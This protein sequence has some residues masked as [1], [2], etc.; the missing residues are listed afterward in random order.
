VAAA[1]PAAQ[2]RTRRPARPH[3]RPERARLPGHTAIPTQT[4]PRTSTAARTA[5]LN[6]ILNGN[7]TAVAALTGNLTA[8]LNR[9]L[10]RNLTPDLTS[11]WARGRLR[12][13]PARQALPV[14]RRRPDAYDCS[15]LVWLAWEHAGL[16]WERMTAAAQWQWLHDRGG[17]VPAN[18]LRPGDLLFYAN[19]PDN[20]ASIHHVAMHVGN[21]RMVEAPQPGIPVRVVP[22]RWEGLYAA[23]PAP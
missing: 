11:D 14:G 3:R 19:N 5:I 10:D 8:D 17:D 13:G 6:T 12:A 18:Q 4:H 23:R 16:A 2:R 21:G 20:S 7:L 22:V 1:R 15:G 9:T